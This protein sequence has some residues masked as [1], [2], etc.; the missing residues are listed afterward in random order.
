MK[1]ESGDHEGSSTRKGLSY[2]FAST[3]TGAEAFSTSTYQR[4]SRLSVKATF[5]ESGDQTGE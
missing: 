4:L 2:M 5:F 3:L 1:R